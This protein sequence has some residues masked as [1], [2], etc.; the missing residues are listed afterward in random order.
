MD[1]I[2]IKNIDLSKDVKF[3]SK[4]KLSINDNDCWVWIGINNIKDLKG[5]KGLFKIQ[6]V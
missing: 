6:N 4:V 1:N 5:E 3:W 2:T